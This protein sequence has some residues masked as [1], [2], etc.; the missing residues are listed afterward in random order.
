[1]AEQEYF[2]CIF[3]IADNKWEKRKSQLF[4]FMAGLFI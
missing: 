2:S 4:T 3:V 1:M